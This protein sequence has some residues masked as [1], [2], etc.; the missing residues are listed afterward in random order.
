MS[1]ANMDQ[2]LT[3]PAGTLLCEYD[4]IRNAMIGELAAG[5][6][7][8][9]QMDALQARCRSELRSLQQELDMLLSELRAEV[10]RLNRNTKHSLL[11]S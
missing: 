11:A 4:A 6:L 8:A 3:I 10:R 9:A 2:S 1:T 7:S 5:T